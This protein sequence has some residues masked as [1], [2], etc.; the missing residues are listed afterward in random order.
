MVV[1]QSRAG[2]AGS[3][4]G[5]VTPNEQLQVVAKERDRIAGE[6]HDD[7]VQAMTAVSLQLQRLLGRVDD[8]D[9]RAIVENARRTTDAAI[10]RLRHMLFVLHPT[11]LEEDGLVLTLRSYLETYVKPVG[12]ECKVLGDEDIEIPI[13]VAALG[14][15]LTHEAATNAVRH[16]GGSS[17][18]ISVSCLP[19]WLKITVV[20][21]GVGFDALS[22][23]TRP[24]HRGIG[25]CQDLAR[26][27][28]GSYEI[29]PGTDC[30]AI[31]EITLPT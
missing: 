11:S 26:T 27:A 5:S 2:D 19:G 29:K 10:N 7:S 9:T 15:R 17:I 24:G 30:G 22:V 18:E 31:V 3:V 13:G 8:P 20:D 21:N 12:L 16:S 4:S 28:L 14:F 1:S 6:L 25:H 23:K